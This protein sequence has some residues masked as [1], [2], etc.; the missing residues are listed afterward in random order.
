MDY[1]GRTPWHGLGIKVKKGISASKMIKAAGLDWEVN[2]RSARG[3][4]IGGQ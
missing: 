3:A 4:R 1:Y 2:M